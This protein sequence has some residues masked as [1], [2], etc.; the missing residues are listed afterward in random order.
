[1]KR[2]P[3]QTTMEICPGRIE[4]LRGAVGVRLTCH[5]GTVWITQEGLARDDFLAAGKSIELFASGLT[6]IESIGQAGASLAIES[7]RGDG[8]VE[9][10]A[11]QPSRALA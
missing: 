3:L 10:T 1:M 2:N 5:R 4:R 8:R 9:D 7:T 6:L 11:D